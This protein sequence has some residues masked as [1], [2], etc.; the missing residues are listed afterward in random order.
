MKRRALVGHLKVGL[1]S[2]DNDKD[3]EIEELK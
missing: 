1:A 3:N 2:D